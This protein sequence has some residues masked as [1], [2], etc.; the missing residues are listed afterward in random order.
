MRQDGKSVYTLVTLAG[1]LAAGTI[2]NGLSPVFAMA[3]RHPQTLQAE[4]FVLIDS[5]GTKRAEMRVTLNGMANLAM[6]DG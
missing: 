4:H 2:A 6:Y 5:N 1:A 3:R